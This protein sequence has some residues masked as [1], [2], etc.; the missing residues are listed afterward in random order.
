MVLVHRR[1][2]RRRFLPRKLPGP[3]P[4]ALNQLLTLFGIIE[5]LQRLDVVGG[6][7]S[8]DHDRGAAGDL[9]ESAR[10]R[11]DDRQPGRERLQH[12]KPETFIERWKQK[13]IGSTV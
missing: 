13:Y 10:A 6:I 11:R 2:Q 9:L 8:L 4:A 5:P 7:A 3:R 12:R 1:R